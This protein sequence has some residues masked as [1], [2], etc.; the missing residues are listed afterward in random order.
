MARRA[1][2]ALVRELAARGAAH[3]ARGQ[4]GSVEFRLNGVEVRILTRDPDAARVFRSA[5][6]AFD[7]EIILA[8]TDDPAHLMLEIALRARTGARGVPGARYRGAAVR[9]G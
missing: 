9:S 4:A 6:A 2:A 1:H 8:S 5:G 7:P 3:D